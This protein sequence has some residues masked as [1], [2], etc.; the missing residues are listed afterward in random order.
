LGDTARTRQGD[1]R[2]YTLEELA[3]IR[4]GAEALG[5]TQ[6]QALERLGE[7]TGDVYLNEL[8]S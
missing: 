7:A 6:A 3:A 2:E 8:A 1:P 4:E 5:L